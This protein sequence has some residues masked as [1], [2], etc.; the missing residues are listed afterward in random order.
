MMS[1]L[2]LLRE[3]LSLWPF[4]VTCTCWSLL[5]TTYGHSDPAASSTISGSS[6]MYSSSTDTSSHWCSQPCL[7]NCPLNQLVTTLISRATLCSHASLQSACLVTQEA[8]CSFSL[9]ESLLSPL[10]FVPTTSMLVCCCCHPG[11]RPCRFC[12]VCWPAAVKIHRKTGAGL[13]G[14]KPVNTSPPLGQ[15]FRCVLGLAGSMG[16]VR[17]CLVVWGIGMQVG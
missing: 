12:I 10:G 3:S 6:L 1:R 7:P 5:C 17:D 8:S 2:P 14:Q 9:C 4:P 16:F 15:I 11:A 13:V